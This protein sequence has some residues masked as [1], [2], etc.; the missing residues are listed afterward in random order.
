[1]SQ[2]GKIYLVGA[3]PGDADLLTIK[4]VKALQQADVILYDAL[5]GEDILSYADAN[6]ELVFVGKRDRNHSM[7]QEDI[8]RLL[9]NY[10]KRGFQVVRLK[11]GDPFIFGRGGEEAEYALSQGVEVVRVPGLSSATSLT[12]LQGIPLTSRGYSNSFWVITATTRTGDLPEDFKK[13]AATNATLVVLMGLRK[14]K[15]IADFF[16]RSG[17][18]DMPFAVIQN[19]SL[20]TEKIALADAQDIV[21]VSEAQS[22]EAPAIIVIGSVVRLHPN[23]WVHQL[24]HSLN[25]EQALNQKAS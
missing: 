17:K 4:A 19:G 23:Y 7:P 3:G 5:V 9:V 22:M 20:P 12:G 10:A 24:S 21:A 18:A 15:L 1:M 6:C 13:A 14:L 8:N 25:F 16:I 11:G 2:I